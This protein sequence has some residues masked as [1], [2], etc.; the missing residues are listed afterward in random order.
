MVT[1]NAAFA[2]PAGPQDTVKRY[3]PAAMPATLMSN[4]V[5]VA[6]VAGTGTPFNLAVGAVHR[7]CP[8]ACRT[9]VLL[10]TIALLMTAC[11]AP[12]PGGPCANNVA[13]KHRDT[14]SAADTTFFIRACLF[15]GLA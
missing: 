4:A 10:L 11:G 12:P 9:F 8:V 1:S 7:F 15:A 5:V 2:V 6:F 14:E 13:E 3:D